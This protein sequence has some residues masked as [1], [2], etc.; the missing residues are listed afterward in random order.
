MAWGQDRFG[1]G[2]SV[3]RSVDIVDTH[4]S[5]NMMLFLYE[6]VATHLLHH[7]ISLE[8]DV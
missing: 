5:D 4:I 2:G 8:S 7:G 1:F 3:E 6:P